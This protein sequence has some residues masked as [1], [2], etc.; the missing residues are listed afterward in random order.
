MPYTKGFVERGSLLYKLT[1]LNG[2]NYVEKINDIINDIIKPQ[3]A[4]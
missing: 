4:H 2:D 1:E 3:M